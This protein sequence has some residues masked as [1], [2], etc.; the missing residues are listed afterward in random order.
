MKPRRLARGLAL[1][2]LYEAEMA[3]HDPFPIL[4][5]RLQ[6]GDYA[7]DV[8]EFAMAL[9]TG[10]A[11]HR[12]G[13]DQTITEHAPGW[14]LAQVAPVDASI[15]RLGAYELLFGGSPAKVAI[16][17]AVELAKEYGSDSSARFVNGVL[18]AIARDPKAA[19]VRER[20]S[21]A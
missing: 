4:Q 18:G 12:E 13:V 9:L 21:G 20:S 14:P 10:V 15:L 7:A 1:E 17:E 19:A 6:E 2:V 16:N 8:A 11:A 5:R 3:R